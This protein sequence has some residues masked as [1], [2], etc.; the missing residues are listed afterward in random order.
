MDG[1]VAYT[2]PTLVPKGT[3]LHVAIAF[4]DQGAAVTD[5]RLLNNG[6]KAPLYCLLRLLSTVLSTV[7]YLPS[8]KQ[9][10]RF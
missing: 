1:R 6:G 7:L 5:I 8:V 9:F 4:Y 3:D 10:G 2:S